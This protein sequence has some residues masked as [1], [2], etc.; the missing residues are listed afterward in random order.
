MCMVPPRSE[1]SGYGE[2]DTDPF[3]RNNNVTLLSLNAAIPFRFIHFLETSQVVPVS[4]HA[5][6]IPGVSPSKYSGPLEEMRSNSMQ[7]CDFQVLIDTCARSCI[8]HDLSIH[9]LAYVMNCLN[10]FVHISRLKTAWRGTCQRTPS[11]KRSRQGHVT[12]L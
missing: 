4:S 11:R 3:L 1:I 6:T 10:T 5:G 9:V 8:P 2:T 12:I 7:V